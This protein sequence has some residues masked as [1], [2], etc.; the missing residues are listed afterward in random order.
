MYVLSMIIGFIPAI[1]LFFISFLTL[2]A[3]TS[4]IKT[5]LLTVGGVGLLLIF[6]YFLNLEF[7]AGVFSNE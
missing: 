5:A 2:K 6:G 7:P 1:I 4:F 3:N